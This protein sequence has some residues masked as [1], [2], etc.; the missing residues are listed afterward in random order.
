[1]FAPNRTST[2]T[3]R[4]ICKYVDQKGL[5]AMLISIQSAG[6]APVVNLR[7]TQAR[8]HAKG[9]TLALKPR[10]DIIRSSKQGVSVVPRKGLMSAKNFKNP[11]K[12][13][14]WKTHFSLSILFLVLQILTKIMR[15]DNLKLHV[16]SQW[17]DRHLRDS[18]VQG[19]QI[20]RFLVARLVMHLFRICFRR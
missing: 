12:N 4:H 6:V 20:T 5:A 16:I 11:Y 2:N 17:V 8:K 19:T 18:S 1:M 15:W 3:C 10:A 7:I 14:C 9:S 13:L